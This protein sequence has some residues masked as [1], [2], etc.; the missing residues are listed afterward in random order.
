MN[1][2]EKL[3]GCALNIKANEICTSN[4]IYNLMYKMYSLTLTF[5][6]WNDVKTVFVCVMLVQKTYFALSAMFLHVE[7]VWWLQIFSKH[8][9]RLLWLR[10]LINFFLLL[11]SLTVFKK[12]CTPLKLKVLS[13][14]DVQCLFRSGSEH[15]CTH[16]MIVVVCGREWVCCQKT[17]KY[18]RILN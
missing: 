3:F 12:F 15:S 14:L 9:L 6:S 8:F 11:L 10:C 1:N 17:T 16:Q 13:W 5:V 2:I 4:I 18:K 7:C